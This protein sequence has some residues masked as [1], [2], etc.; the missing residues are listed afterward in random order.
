M[1]S[2]LPLDTLLDLAKEAVDVATQRLGAA[3]AARANAQRQMD[4]LQDYR[5][6]YL[7]RLQNMMAQ[8]MASSDCQNYQ[9]FIS[10]LD[11]ALQQQRDVLHR[12]DADLAT[13]REQW[14]QAQRKHNAFDALMARNRRARQTIEARREQRATDEFAGRSAMRLANAF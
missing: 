5:Q 4:M 12:A 11:D 3:T 7:I 1:A 13:C 8:G 9:R 10:T 14:Q 2:T 6:D